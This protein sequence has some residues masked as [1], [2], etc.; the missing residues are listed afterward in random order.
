MNKSLCRRKRRTFHWQG[1]CHY[2][3]VLFCFVCLFVWK[4]LLV[5]EPA[6][7]SSDHLRGFWLAK[8]RHTVFYFLFS[9]MTTGRL[10]LAA[11]SQSVGIRSSRIHL[12][13][14]VSIVSSL[15]EEPPI[16]TRYL[17]IY[18][19]YN[20][21]GNRFHL[22]FFYLNEMIKTFFFYYFVLVSIQKLLLR[23]LFK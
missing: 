19:E 9:A 8:S 12:F 4:L 16:I 23:F 20:I 14:L 17:N 18:L 21:L 15:L 1:F 2:Y 10:V 5:C 11:T 7:H 13:F 22:D 6:N 3:Q